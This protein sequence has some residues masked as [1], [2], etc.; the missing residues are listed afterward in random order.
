ME[1]VQLYIDGGNFYHLVLKKLN[2][3]ELDFDFDA[4]AKFLVGDRT[5]PEMGK[6]YYVGTVREK[7]GDARSKA[8][9]SQQNTLF[10]KL[11][12]AKW[13]VKTSK[14]RER[15]E[16]LV[17]DD[18]VEDCEKIRRTGI[19]EIY[20]TRQRE[21]GIDVKIVT[22]MFIGAM[23]NQYDT[24]IIVSSDTDLVPA[25]DSI[26][27]RLKK[28]VEYVGFSIPDPRDPKNSTRPLQSMIPRTDVQRT[29][30]EADLKPFIVPR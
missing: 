7:M 10:S 18:R 11:I 2:R 8:A 12:F 9:M 29:L 26:R 28:K 22:D 19:R 25:I 27:R 13:E 17:I 30:V 20:F 4:F 21:K 14:L 6:R 1:R 15:R 16:K 23:D 5:L 3:T 24:A